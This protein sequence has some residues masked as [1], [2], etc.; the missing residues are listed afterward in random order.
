MVAIFTFWFKKFVRIRRL[1][2]V[3]YFAKV[4]WLLRSS[5]LEGDVYLPSVEW[6]SRV[7]GGV[8][9]TGRRMEHYCCVVRPLLLCVVISSGRWCYSVVVASVHAD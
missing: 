7:K 1:L 9:Y 4:R 8:T 5:Y 2:F 6:A 3:K